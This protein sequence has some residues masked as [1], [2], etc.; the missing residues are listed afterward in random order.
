MAA[1]RKCSAAQVSYTDHIPTNIGKYAAKN[2]PAGVTR[3]FSCSTSDDGEKH[4]GQ[5]C[6]V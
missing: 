5:I 6:Q 3:D 2:V 4:F 1:G